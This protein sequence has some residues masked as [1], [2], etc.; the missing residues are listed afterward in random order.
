MLLPVRQQLIV[1]QLDLVLEFSDIHFP[2][3]EM[4]K[5]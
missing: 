2:Q 1:K 5:L 4:S 3:K